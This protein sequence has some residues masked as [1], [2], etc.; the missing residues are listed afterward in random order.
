ML[1]GVVVDKQTKEPL[2]QA[3]IT[4][5]RTSGNIL[6]DKNGSFTISN[7][8]PGDSLSIR[9]IGYINQSVIVAANTKI[10]HIELEKGRFDLKEVIITN[11]VNNLISSHTLSSIDLNMQPVKSAQDLL[12]L[13]P[14]L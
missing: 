2:E 10:L 5:N 3:N 13:I 11:H 12:K 9:F 7:L 14:G 8:H 4:V 6:T 1:K